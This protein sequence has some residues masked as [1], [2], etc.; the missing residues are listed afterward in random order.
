MKQKIGLLT[1]VSADNCGS[2]LQA[3]AMKYIFGEILKRDAELISFFPL[4]ARKMYKTF[5]FYMVKSLKSFFRTFFRLRSIVGQRLDYN[6][7]R[8]QYLCL[9]SRKIKS[10]EELN[11]LCKEYFAICVGSDQVW[12][13]K[14]PDFD[15]AYFLENYQGKKVSYAA[16]LGGQETIEVP[17]ELRRYKP[18]IDKYANISVREPQGKMILQQVSAKKIDVCIDPTLLVPVD[19]WDELAGDSLVEGEYIFF[20]S[21]N[22]GDKALNRLVQSAAKKLGLPV[23]VINASRWIEKDPT[24]FG[25]KLA[26]K[27]GPLA[28][29]SLMKHAHCVFVQSLHGSIFASIY[30][31]NFWFLSNRSEDVLDHRSENILALLGARHRTIRPN[32]FDSVDLTM[33]LT[34]DDNLLLQEERRK[35]LDYLKKCFECV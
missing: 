34:C 11:F 17:E 7:F 16:S 27:G 18:A 33:P 31:R 8:K 9:S 19:V 5:H 22:Y 20:Y 24:E 25:F 3:F 21:Y 35:S 15:S 6:R 12:N 26:T 10:K 28:F 1:L 14:M 13:V 29:L 4:N 32:N 2:L 30:Q 23:Y